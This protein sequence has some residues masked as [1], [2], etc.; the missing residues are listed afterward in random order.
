MPITGGL[1]YA[2]PTYNY[3]GAPIEEIKALNLAKAQ[4]YNLVKGNADHLKEVANA[5]DLRNVD[6]ELKQ[7][8]LDDIDAKFSQLT[9]DGDYQN[10]GKLVNDVTNSVKN[11]AALKDALSQRQKEV[12]YYNELKKRFDEGKITP[13]DYRYAVIST[14][15]N[16]DKPSNYNEEL[17]TSDNPFSGIDVIDDKTK[18]IYD[19][20]YKRIENWKASSQPIDINGRSVKYDKGK[21]LIIDAVTGQGVNY[22]EVYNALKTEVE[23][24]YA[25]FIEQQKRVENFKRFYNSETG[26][27]RNA[28]REDIP[29]TDSD[30][31]TLMTGISENSLKKLEEDAKNPKEKGA[32]LAFE[33]AKEARDNVDLTDY[34]SIYQTYQNRNTIDKYVAPAAEKA[35]YYDEDHH[36][37]T[38]ENSKLALQHAY[39]KAEIDYEKKSVLALPQNVSALEEFTAQDYQNSINEQNNLQIKLQEAKQKLEQAKKTGNIV[40]IKNAEKEVNDLTHLNETAK[41]KQFDFVKQLS[42]KHKPLE[43]EYII[44]NI[45]E[46]VNEIEQNPHKY[47]AALVAE[48]RKVKYGSYQGNQNNNSQGSTNAANTYLPSINSSIDRPSAE[49]LYNLIGKEKNKDNLL[50]LAITNENNSGR[51]NANIADAIEEAKRENVGFAVSYQSSVLGIDE[52]T[53]KAWEREILDRTRDL[54]ANS[55]TNWRIG[56]KS[57]DEIVSN[58]VDGF[59]FVNQEGKTVKP[60]ITKSIVRPQ[61]GHI[62]GRNTVRITLKDSEGHPVYRKGDKNSLASFTLTP[63]DQQGISVLYNQ[64]GST[65]SSSNDANAQKQGI[66][67]LGYTNFGSAF[68]NIKLSTMENGQSQN[69]IIPTRIGDLY[70]KITKGPGGFEMFVEQDGKYVPFTLKNY[71][72]KESN[73]FGSKDQVTELLQLN[74]YGYN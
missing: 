67:I 44:S 73:T 52:N 64:L 71:Q 50:K 68:S 58:E 12:Q 54:V 30:I 15:K 13:D 25:P 60:D 26:T 37:L 40:Y 32:K 48:A 74:G 39:K 22:N 27:F 41:T 14:K 35:S 45:N 65:L 17:M 10:A 21:G 43:K 23:N 7:Q 2:T 51:N 24:E 6:A 33:K 62:S 66:K 4:E 59:K 70:T 72:G 31:K 56:D 18:E 16:N 63:E 20:V 53:D 29:L 55:A 49:Y 46:V 1:S 8:I 3:V 9:A 47:S 57:L 5:L 11:N 28:S 34:N 42:D 61:F 69:I 36:F 19:T 38:D